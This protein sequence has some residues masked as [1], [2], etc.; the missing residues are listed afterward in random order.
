M[1]AGV[2]SLGT[3]E[4]QLQRA[5]YGKVLF[6]APG[7]NR[8]AQLITYRSIRGDNPNDWEA[9]ESNPRRGPSKASRTMTITLQANSGSATRFPPTGRGCLESKKRV[10]R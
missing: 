2:Q 8:T 5:A 10:Q 9:Q 4:G 3:I 6:E 1:D 7:K